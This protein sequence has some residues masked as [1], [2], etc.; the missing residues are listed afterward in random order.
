MIA[1][2]QT[3]SVGPTTSPIR[4]NNLVIAM[5]MGGNT[6]AVTAGTAAPNSDFNQANQALGSAGIEDS[7]KWDGGAAT[8]TFSFGATGGDDAILFSFSPP[9]PQSNVFMFA[10]STT[11][12]SGIISVTEKA[13]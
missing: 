3:I 10:H 9:S 7:L 4:A 1:I 11:G 13:R 2:D 8:A 6:G 5:C 12:N